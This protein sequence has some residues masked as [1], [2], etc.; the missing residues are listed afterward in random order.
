MGTRTEDQ[1]I[2]RAAELKGKASAS[3]ANGALGGKGRKPS[4]GG[5]MV[6]VDKTKAIEK[7]NCKFVAGHDVKT[8]PAAVGD[9]AKKDRKEA[10]NPLMKVPVQEFAKMVKE[11]QAAKALEVFMRACVNAPACCTYVTVCMKEES[12]L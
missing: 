10:G 3:L 5:A 2:K 12:G 7:V 6:D 11:Q 1:C 9:Q 8:G 4:T